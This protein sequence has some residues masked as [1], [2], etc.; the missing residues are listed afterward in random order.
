[1]RLLD[2]AC[3][4]GRIAPTERED[5]WKII[6]TVGEETAQRMFAEGRVPVSKDAGDVPV[7]V[8]PANNAEDAFLAL[9]DKHIE[10]GKS[11]AE[12]WQLATAEAGINLYTSEEN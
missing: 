1:M 7:D 4:V 12:A 2:D 10:H 6:G 5:Y 9:M 11:H 8:T 3:A